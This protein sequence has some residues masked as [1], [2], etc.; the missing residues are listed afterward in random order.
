M[1]SCYSQASLH[2][3][4]HQDVP[5][6]PISCP[7]SLHIDNDEEHIFTEEN[8]GPMNA[9]VATVEYR[10]P[11]T[12]LNPSVT[13]VITIPHSPSSQ[14]PSPHPI[15]SPTGAEISV[16]QTA[17]STEPPLKPSHGEDVQPPS[18]TVEEEV[19]NVEVSIGVL[20]V[21]ASSS[22]DKEVV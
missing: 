21:H 19:P 5:L 18:A 13:D 3:Q 14:I 12:D 15:V 6:S 7:R 1:M 17:L 9:P 11:P 22:A 2:N 20:E 16:L 10:A 4:E 8:I